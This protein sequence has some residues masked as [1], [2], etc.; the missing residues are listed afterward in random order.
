MKGN[1]KSGMKDIHNNIIL[2]LNY[3]IYHVHTGAAPILIVGKWKIS[4]KDLSITLRWL[5]ICEVGFNLFDLL[6]LDT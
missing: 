4:K 3:K 6:S 5:N 1:S 2:C